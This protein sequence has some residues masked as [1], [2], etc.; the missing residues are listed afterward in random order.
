MR[1]LLLSTF[2]A[3]QVGDVL[4]TNRFLATGRGV[5]GNPLVSA[6]MEVLGQ[7]WWIPKWALV[8]A[9]VAFMTS[10]SADRRVTVPALAILN[11]LYLYVVVNNYSL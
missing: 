7:Y 11:A 8:V 1:T 4:S 6:I 9:F 10:R 3:L 5:E 2:T